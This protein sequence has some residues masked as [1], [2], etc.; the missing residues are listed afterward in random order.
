MVW[1]LL[2]FVPVWSGCDGEPAIGITTALPVNARVGDNERVLH[3]MCRDILRAGDTHIK[4]HYYRHPDGK[5]VF[6][7]VPYCS[8]IVKKYAR[9]R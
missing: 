5:R 6:T 4:I 2:A 7:V 3:A 8:E 1:T 9:Y